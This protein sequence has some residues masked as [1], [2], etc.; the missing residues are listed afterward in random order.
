MLSKV[1]NT[2]KKFGMIRKGNTVVVG[3]SGGVD[4]VVL[5]HLLLQLAAEYK[6][7]LIAAHLNHSLRG[8]ESDRD[9]AFVRDLTKKLNIKFIGKKV[10]VKSLLKKGESLQDAARK[11]RYAFFEETAKKYKARRIATG[12]N[13]D[14]QAETVIMRFL[15]GA[16][17]RG[18][19]GIPP[20]RDNYIRP[21]I[22]A[23]RKE[24]ERYATDNEL[25][26][27]KDSSNKSIKYLRNKIRLKLMPILEGYNP[28]IRSDMARLANILARDEDYLKDQ[29]K[30]SYKSL[31]IRQDANIISLSLKKL[32]NAHDAIKA[33]V[34]F[35]TVEEL[36]GSSRGF[37]SYHIEDFLKLLHN[38]APNISVNLPHAVTIYKEYD[39]VTIARGQRSAVSGRKR[40]EGLSFEQALKINGETSV[41]AD[42]GIR[43]ADFKTKIQN[44]L[45]LILSPEGRGKG[46][47]EAYFDYDKLKLPLTIRNFRP[48][49]RFMPLGMKGHKKLKALFIEKKIV[50]RKRGLIPII[51]SGNEIVWVA[52]VRQAEYAKVGPKTKMV[53]KIEMSR[54]G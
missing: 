29:A 21:L 9:A 23:T 2:I 11:A 34:F 13:L 41:I 17:L 54:L 10:D 24:I 47:G 38:N 20:V 42:S 8:K 12:H 52:G 43:I 40:T 27:V 51:V 5:L 16:G 6:L 31:V 44:P 45:T 48:G 37:Y 22:D 49:D 18:L 14:D 53:L 4:S 36:V 28:R 32:R 50:R 46:E 7:S 19:S 3:V 25:Q 1:K 33:R 39:I 35:M 15:K 30:D 26:F